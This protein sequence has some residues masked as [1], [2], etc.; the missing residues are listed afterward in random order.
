MYAAD[1]DTDAEGAPPSLQEAELRPTD[2]DLRALDVPQRLEIRLTA[3]KV[4]ARARSLGT[5]K[6]HEVKPLQLTGLKVGALTAA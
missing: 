4:P 5:L 1:R 2:S 6:V 3:L